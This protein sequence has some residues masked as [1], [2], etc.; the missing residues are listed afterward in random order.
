MKN[1]AAQAAHGQGRVGRRVA[2]ESASEV[3]S[4]RNDGQQSF[5][6]A[7]EYPRSSAKSAG[8]I[9]ELRGL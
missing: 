5:S 8:E 1:H 6:A 2:P 9:S 3:L 7:S 4:V